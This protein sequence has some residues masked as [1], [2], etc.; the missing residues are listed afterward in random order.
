MFAAHK[1]K[2]SRTSVEIA[3]KSKFIFLFGVT[4]RNSVNFLNF[5]ISLFFSKFSQLF[6]FDD[7]TSDQSLTISLI[8]LQKIVYKNI[9]WCEDVVPKKKTKLC[10]A[11]SS[12]SWSMSCCHVVVRSPNSCSSNLNCSVRTASS[13]SN[14]LSQCK[15]SNVPVDLMVSPAI[16]WWHSM[17]LF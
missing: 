10:G 13:A 5:W 3:P 11:T 6:W 2:K 14:S 1:Y 9:S 4:N 16:N 7:L 15:C 17:R 12:A 8:T